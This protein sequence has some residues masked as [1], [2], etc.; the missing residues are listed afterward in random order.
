M[1]VMLDNVRRLIHGMDK[2][3]ATPIEEQTQQQKDE[4]AQ[5]V[6]GMRIAT[7]VLSAYASPRSLIGSNQTH[8]IRQRE[9]HLP[10]KQRFDPFNMFIRIRRDLLPVSQTVFMAEWLTHLPLHI[11][12]TAISTFF[13]ILA[14]MDEEM[15]FII[16]VPEPASPLIREILQPRPPPTANPAAVNQLVEMGFA[17]RAAERALV[18]ARNNIA[19]AADLLI[20]MPHLFP[21]EPEPA[22]PAQPAGGAPVVE[23]ADAP[24][25]PPADET[26]AAE[27]AVADTQPAAEAEAAR[28][29]ADDH[30]GMEVDEVDQAPTP[31]TM[32]ERQRKE[33]D[34]LRDAARKQ[35][36][37]R[38]IQLLDTNEELVHDVLPAFGVGVEGATDI[39]GC[40]EEA[41]KESP[42]RHAALSS[43][44]RL[45]AV[46]ARSKGPID[47]PAEQCQRFKGLLEGLITPNTP[48]PPFLASYL[49][50]AEALLLMSTTIAEVKLGE[51]AKRDI[52]KHVDLGNLSSF[53]IELCQSTLASD[54]LSREDFMGSLRLAVI[55]TRHRQDWVTHDLLQHIVKHFKK[56]D[57]KVT[58]SYGYFAMLT[59]HA[60]DSQS[61]LQDIMRREI[62]EWMTPQRNK[63]S[64][65]QH[66]V[67]Q[68]RQMMYR[69]PNA[70]LDAVQEETALVDPGPA[71]SVYHLRA[72]DDNKDKAPDAEGETADQDKKPVAVTAGDPFIKSALDSFENKPTMDFLVSELGATMQIVHQEE[73]SRRAGTPYS[74]SATQAYTYIGLL[75]AQLVELTGSYMS[76][77]TAFMAAVRQGSI[78]GTG[79][80]KAGF[81]AVLTDLVCA[82]TLSDV[83][84]SRGRETHDVR[85]V[86]VS[87]WATS[88]ITS[89]CANV[90]YTPDGKDLPDDLVAVRKIVLDGIA[91]A[92]KDSTSA[93]LEANTRYGRLWALGQLIRRLLTQRT[94]V[95]PKPNDKTCLQLAKGMLEKNFVGLMTTTLSDIDLNYPDIRNVLESLLKALE[96][97]TKISNKWGKTENKPT[98]GEEIDDDESESSPSSGDDEDMSMSLSEDEEADPP[99]LYRNSAL[100]ILGGDIDV[101]DDDDDMDDDMEEDDD[102]VSA[103]S[104]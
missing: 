48:C 5:L 66:F 103:R 49:V 100:G 39:L 50:A 76:A 43:R 102:L 96:H 57:S 71:S 26:P 97:L 53:L 24:A 35:V 23:D 30:A 82:V 46:F 87:S 98:A 19:S 34:E 77:K 8:V 44:L 10:V 61:S 36:K 95:I 29:S 27:P 91:K 3:P 80:G 40:L 2:Y 65:V 9:Q 42:Q 73:A 1:A 6:Q 72:K 55:L 25:Q 74:E 101:D 93:H 79:K 41:V 37:E 86:T 31:T 70:F 104:G 7:S 83:Q 58:G 20:S 67:R 84:E 13:V 94:G 4:A 45:I 33:L 17:R 21:D 68:L 60:F 16:G 89:L 32:W 99:D 64:D 47:L 85:R 92:L 11:M 54:D 28:A 59:R 62:A 12:R 22:Q 63:V 52:V 90:A 56:P 38:S 15:E 78:Y 14:G 69:S 51:D 88:L 81:S 75:L 18:R